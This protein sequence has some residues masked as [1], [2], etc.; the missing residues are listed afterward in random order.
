[1]QLFDKPKDLESKSTQVKSLRIFASMVE[2][3]VFCKVTDGALHDQPACQRAIIGQLFADIRGDFFKFGNLVAAIKQE[4]CDGAVESVAI[5]D[6]LE[7][8]QPLVAGE[9]DR[10]SEFGVFDLSAKVCSS[11]KNRH[12]LRL[13]W[14][15][16][17][18]QVR[19]LGMG[20]KNGGGRGCR[21]CGLERPNKFSLKRVQY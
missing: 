4:W 5:A 20:E 2:A 1:V 11:Q 6:S 15:A 3:P 19:S 12:D 9:A 17:Q 13:F 14:R 21:N 10:D 7:Q 18:N 16:R 8:W